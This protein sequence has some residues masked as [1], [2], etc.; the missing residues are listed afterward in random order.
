[1]SPLEI[2]QRDLEG[3]IKAAEYFTDKPVFVYRPREKEGFA[4]LDSK[5]NAALGSMVTQG[6]HSGIALSVFMPVSD[7]PEADPYEPVFEVSGIVRVAENIIQNMSA[8]GTQASAEDVGLHVI[9]L[10]RNFTAFG[11][12]NTVACAK[13]AMTPRGALADNP[14]VLTA[15]I[16]RGSTC[17][18]IM[19]PPM[20]VNTAPTIPARRYNSTGFL[21]A[22]AGRKR[23]MGPISFWGCYRSRIL[24]IPR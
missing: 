15:C 9:L 21:C 22:L 24:G 18:L 4:A 11:L 16:T 2:F 19:H 8:G 3:R 7:I 13:D 23:A 1:M 14:N 10:L 20:E 5:I 12:Y 17:R 6:G